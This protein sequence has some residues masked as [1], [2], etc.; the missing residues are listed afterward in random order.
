MKISSQII[1]LLLALGLAFSVGCTPSSRTQEFL[2]GEGVGLFGNRPQNRTHFIAVV[3]LEGQPLLESAQRVNGQ[4]QI[5]PAAL[6]KLELEQ[7]EALVKLKDL[8]SEIRVLY[9]YKMVL[10]G[11][12]I[13]APIDLAESIRALVNVAYVESEGKFS[14]PKTIETLGEGFKLNEKNSVNFIGAEAFHAAGF[15][16]QG[17]TVGIIDTGIDFT[18]SMFLGPGTVD[19]FKAVN[20]DQETPLFP[21]KKVI[22]GIDLVGTKFD[23]GS[24]DFANRVPTPDLNPIDEGGHGTHVAGTVAGIG[25]DVETYSG[26][27]PEAVLYAIKVFGADGS[28]GDGTVI[29]ALEYAADP[30]K[31]GKL[32]DQLDV[33]NLSLGSSFGAPHIL[34]GEA[35]GRL[36]RA[37]T[38]VIAAA[39]NSGDTPYIVGSPSVVEEAL[40]VAAGID[41]T[42]HNWQFDAVELVLGTQGP[43]LVEAIE[44]P[45]SKPVREA[46]A[47]AGAL[48]DIGLA[49]VDLTEAQKLSLKGKVALI[50]R[51]KVAFADKL[52]RAYEAG[53]VGAIVTNNAPGDAFAMGGNGQFPI[54]AIMVT[55]AIGDQIRIKMLSDIVSVNFQSPEKIEKPALIDTITGFS[56]RALFRCFD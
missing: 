15:T 11:F 9:T 16:G 36:S 47:V 39:G 7:K 37:G 18:H 12:A 35:M 54:P 6:A 44:G 32:D 26:V 52:K 10:N 51:G 41:H 21:N 33:V 24:P 45:I 53:A 20:P 5:A 34:Y 28:T 14:R 50:A 40:S 4:L 38:A 46:G 3:K 43:V 19:A 23:A 42:S 29:A 17:M 27:A 2:G 25:D 30:N 31:D 48:V 49:D 13:V 22:G 55:Q 56:S 8:S 1:N